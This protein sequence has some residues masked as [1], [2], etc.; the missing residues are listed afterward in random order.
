MMRSI[1]ALASCAAVAALLLV[2]PGSVQGQEGLKVYISADMGT[3]SLLVQY[4][5]R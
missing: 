1:P 2:G 4:C 3:S 5:L